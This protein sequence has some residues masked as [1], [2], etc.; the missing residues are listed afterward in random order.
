MDGEKIATQRL[1]NNR[2]DE[3]FDQSYI[4]PEKLT[5]EKVKVTVKFQALPDHWAGGV[6]GVRTK[7]AGQ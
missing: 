2:P 6:F 1:E 3:F 5:K 4:L 7:T